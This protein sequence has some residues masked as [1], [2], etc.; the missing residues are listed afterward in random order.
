MKRLAKT[1]SIV[2]MLCLVLMAVACAGSETTT[3]GKSDTT[4]AP[5]SDDTTTTT[6]DEGPDLSE[7]VDLVFYVMGDAPNDENA[8]EEAINEKL[9]AELNTTVDFRFSTWTDFQQKYSTELTTGNADL[10]Y[11]A[12]WLNY[13]LLANEGAFLELDD[14]LGT[15]APD[16]ESLIGDGN[17]NMCRVNGDLYA[18]PNNWP[19]YVPN[20]VTYREDLREKYDLPRP[21]SIEN[22][23]AFLTGIQENEPDQGLLRV[24]TEESQGL[25]RAF[26]AFSVVNFK[27]PWVATD[28]L[29]YGLAADYNTPTEIYDYWF[30]D[31]FVEDC[32]LMKDWADKGFWSKSAL[33]DTNDAEAYKNGLCVAIV[34]GQNPNKQIDAMNSFAL[35]HPDWKTE[36]ITYGEINGVMYPGHAT[37]NGTSIVRGTKHPERA[38]MV[39]NYFMTNEE[40]NRLVQAGIEG[41][42]YELVDGVYK[43]LSEDF[44]Y[45]AFNTWNLRVNDYKLV[46]ES[47]IILQEMFDKYA[48]MAEKTK[49]P[50]VNIEGGFS[51]DYTAYQTERTAVSNVLRQYLAPIQAGL[52]GDVDAAIEEFR[53]KV[54]EAGIEVCREGFKEQWQAYCDEYGYN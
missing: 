30:S 16:L 32:K 48:V 47:D 28:G 36:Y 50:G 26:D 52:V 6:G 18:I 23:E 42:H 13:G 1:L 31:E 40:M 24:T 53:T 25:K 10:I 34:A 19:E 17:L 4:T 2:L 21:D 15:Y 3:T 45:E 11:I 27:Y 43:N 41:T 9:L 22:L 7:R 44:N 35:N 8:V 51:E 37:Q 54:T 29:A 46:Q 5:G 12:G 38:M 14:L 39:L 33:S 49:F 20:G